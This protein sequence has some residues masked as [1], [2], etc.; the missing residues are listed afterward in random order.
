MTGLAQTLASLRHR[1]GRALLTALGT[2]L[3]IGTIVALLAVSA[4]AT[5]TAGSFIRLGPGEL[6]LF[7]KDASDPTTSVLPQSLIATLG[8]QRW[9]ASAQGLALL[10]SELSQS[11]GAIVFG[12]DPNGFETSRMVFTSGHA[13]T[14]PNQIVIGDQLAPQLHAHV[15]DILTVAHRRMRVAGVFHLGISEQDQGAFIPLSTAQAITGHTGEVTTIAVKVSPGMRVPAAKRLIAQRFPGLL[16]ITDPDVALRAGANGQLIANVTLVIVVLALLI[17]GIGVMNTM[18]M[19]VIERRTEFALL[20]AV[21]WSGPQVA[22]LVLTE[23]MIVSIAGAA[24]GIII[25][26]LGA[27]L[28]VHALGAAAFVSPRVTAWVLGRALLIGILIGVLGGLYPAWR[29]AHLSPARALAQQ[30]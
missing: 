22:G 11:P 3:G 9:V 24:G 30:Y 23:G 7:Q 12:A 4:G 16:V 17:G 20:S 2:A 26:I 27:Q 8:R 28:L 13:Y 21:G 14:Q 25:G 1:P 29:A 5:Q 10:V 18:L 15:G 6:G 19:S